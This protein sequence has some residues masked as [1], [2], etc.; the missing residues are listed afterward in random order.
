DREVVRDAKPE[1]VR[2]V[3]RADRHLVVE[4]EDRRRRLRQGEQLPRCGEAAL[5]IEL[6]A[7]D[8][9]VGRQE[10]AAGEGGA[11]A[12]ETSGGRCQRGG[13]GDRRDAAMAEVEQVLDGRMRPA[14]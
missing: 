7:T 6:A 14:G 10:L 13:T 3:E 12:G 2:G 9:L 11:I 4:R 1:R 8:Q 5:E